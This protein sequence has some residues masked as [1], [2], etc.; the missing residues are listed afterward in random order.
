MSPPKRRPPAKRAKP[1]KRPA[2][3][4]IS[5]AC[6]HCGSSATC[7]EGGLPPGWSFQVDGRRAEY[8]CVACARHNIRAIE[9]KLPEEWWA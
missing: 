7:P 5:R 2:E 3:P 9:G 4:T 8:L 1:A 6:G